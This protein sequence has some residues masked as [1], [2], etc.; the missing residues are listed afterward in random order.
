MRQAGVI[1]AA[2]VYALEHMVDRMADDHANAKLLAS[3]LAELPMVDLDP[4]TIETNIVIF[5]VRGDAVGLVRAL[6]QAGVLATMPAPGRVRMVTHYGIERADVEEALERVRHA[7][8]A[9]A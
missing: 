9:L 2:G 8:A 3:G 5:G 1:A 6:K 7:A 4:A